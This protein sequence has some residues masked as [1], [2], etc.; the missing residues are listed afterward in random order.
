MRTLYHFALHPASRQARIALAEKKLKVTESP[1]NPWQLDKGDW[2]E[3]EKVTP[4]GVPPT[5]I[6]VIPSGK[7]VITGARAICEYANDGSTRHPLLAEDIV[8]RAEAR[9]LADWMDQKFTQEVDALILHE[10]VEKSVAG[11]GSADTA[12]LREGRAALAQHLGYF[13]WLLDQRDWLAGRYFSLADIAV[14]AHISCLDFLGEINWRDWPTLKDWYQK[15]KSRP[16]MRPLLNDRVPGF[17]AP[18][19]YTDLDF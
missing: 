11:L 5:L 13:C 14:A 16:S 1:V 12:V 4:E 8:E 17:R 10:K 18:R 7:V 19:H 15:V 9:R 2:K 3:F 6:D